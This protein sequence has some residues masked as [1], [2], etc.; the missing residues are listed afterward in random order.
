MTAKSKVLHAVLFGA[1]LL[2]T[3]LAAPAQQ[4]I[5]SLE[6]SF[7]NPG[8]R[9]M[10]FGGAFVA[11][12]DDATAAFANPAGLVQL[13]RPEVSLERR[14][15]SYSTPFVAGGRLSGAPS[16]MGIDTTPGLR[17]GTS[18]ED[19]SALAF[20]SYVQPLR[21]A[22]VAL[23]RHQLA[24]F[25]AVTTT[26]SLFRALP[27]GGVERFFDFR[28]HVRLDF[29]T[30]GASGA[31]RVAEGFSLGLGIV[32]FQGRLNM[33][34]EVF[35]TTEEA[36]YEPNP[37]TPD[38]VFAAT[39]FRFDSTDWG[40]LAGFLWQIDK[41]WS[42][43]GV[44]RQGPTFELDGVAV[45]GPRFDPAVPPG[46]IVDTVSGIPWRFPDVWGLGVSFR[47]AGGAVTASFE[48]DRVEYSTLIDSLDRG[49]GDVE[50]E[51]DDAN[52][53]R[54]GFEYAFLRSKPVVA[55]RF[56]A[57]LDPDHRIRSTS[58]NPFERARF[59]AGKNELHLAVGLGLAFQSFQL[60]LGA[61]FSNLVDTAA[62][63]AIYSF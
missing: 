24:N 59:P 32:Y 23:Y 27:G 42:L 18:R 52:D 44:Y 61:D 9:S 47:S 7:S 14:H 22:S 29:V 17:S 20:L 43:G 39:D 45:A 6:F 62:V 4:P 55:L 1:G 58:A 46:T 37:L 15:W 5:S 41:R 38:W 11:L 25:K 16:G 8:A 31:Y 40:M 28:N 53:L 2:S 51:L 10:G 57:W 54:A 50:S 48:W 33:G 63:S 56:G 19:L 13:I 26:D 60:D 49:L 3:A 36:F 21:D 12:A 35:V 34:T 30:S